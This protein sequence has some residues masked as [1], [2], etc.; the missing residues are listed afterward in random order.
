MIN[1][2]ENESIEE[3]RDRVYEIMNQTCIKKCDI[4]I[5][6]EGRRNYSSQQLQVVVLDIKMHYHG[7]YQKS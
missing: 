6:N 1:A 2:H 5:S 4:I 7:V 3:Y